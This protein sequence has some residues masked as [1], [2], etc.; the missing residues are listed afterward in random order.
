MGM[1]RIGSLTAALRDGGTPGE[2]PAAVI[3]SAT[4]PR[5]RSVG[6]PLAKLPDAVEM[7]GV[8]APGVVVV[9]EV[10]RRARTFS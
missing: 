5:Q 8:A 9:G 3:A 10:A 1:S 2:T 7:A 4:T 6:A